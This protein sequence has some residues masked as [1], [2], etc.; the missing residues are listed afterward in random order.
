MVCLKCDHKRPKAAHSSEASAEPVRE[1]GG[2]PNNNSM[3]FVGG[4]SDV[5]DQS[6]AGQCRQSQ[7]RGVG[8]WRFVDEG[9]DDGSHSKSWNEASGFVDFPIA[10]G[11]TELSR[12]LQ[13]RDKWKLKMLERS[14]GGMRDMANDD[15]SRSA[16]IPRSL[17]L[18][19]CTDDEEMSDWFGDG[20]LETASALSEPKKFGF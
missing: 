11:K 16:S 3:N 15:G 5:N 7:D 17:E 12:N 20:K 2:Y 13:K 14:K 10:G 8:M 9:D 4:D 6:Y 1:D 18:S 19:D